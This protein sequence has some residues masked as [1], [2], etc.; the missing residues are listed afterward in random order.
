MSYWIVVKA[1]PGHD[2]LVVA[3]VTLAGFETFAPKTRAQ[4]GARWR[5][6]S[7]FGGYFFARVEER[8]R[9]IERTI[10][11]ASVV[12]FGPSPARCPDAEIAKL[13]AR[14]DPDGVVRLAS[15][16]PPRASPVLAPGARVVV[17]DGPL[18]GFNGLYA[19]MPAHERELVL[20]DI[21]GAARSVALAAGR[22]IAR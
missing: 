17:V 9:A 7:L 10:G 11:V 15:C 20:L 5:T 14:A 4:V 3:G 18:A 12:K 1:V 16:P 2:R 21:L 8:W 19:G 13:L 6:V 22:I